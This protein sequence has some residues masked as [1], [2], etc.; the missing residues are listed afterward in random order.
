MI[1]CIL[2]LFFFFQN[3]TI[4][5]TF[6]PLLHNNYQ[7]KWQNRLQQST[8]SIICKNMPL[9][10][11]RSQRLMKDENTHT[12][13]PVK[14]S[15]TYKNRNSLSNIFRYFFFVF[16]IQIL[17]ISCCISTHVFAKKKNCDP[18]T[19]KSAKVDRY[20]VLGI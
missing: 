2:L 6:T 3:V 13:L 10:T 16:L 4:T 19:N 1:S 5:E 9:K 11:F 15:C 14:Q 20:K 17:T 8:F 18:E 7:T 12:S